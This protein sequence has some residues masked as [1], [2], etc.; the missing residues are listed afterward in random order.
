VNS[1]RSIAVVGTRNP[2]AEGLARAK[3]LRA[4]PRS[5]DS[6][7]KI[8]SGQAPQ[9]DADHGEADECRDGS[10]IALEI[11]CETTAAA[12]PGDR[13][14]D[15]PSLRY[16]READC[17]VGP[18][19][20]VDHPGAGSR[21]GSGCFWTLIAAVGKDAFDEWEQAAGACVEDQRDAVAVLD[22]GGMNGDAQQQAERVDQDMPLATRNL[23]ARVVALRIE[24]RPPF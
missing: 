14:L 22:A 23:L 9:H 17:G 12:D 4:D 19:D 11:P 6:A 10:G 1:P 21:S 5:L 20:D 18:L 13:S 16:D 2:S 8:C 3:R 7:A 24:R 15:D